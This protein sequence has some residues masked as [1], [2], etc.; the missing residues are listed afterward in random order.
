MITTLVRAAQQVFLAIWSAA[1][2]FGSQPKPHISP[3]AEKLF[4]CKGSSS[5]YL[6]EKIHEI[7]FI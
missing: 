5:K 2:S 1:G 4:V 6:K 7:E 3:F